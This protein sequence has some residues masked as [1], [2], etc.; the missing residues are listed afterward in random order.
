MRRSTFLRFSWLGLFL[1][2]LFAVGVYSQAPTPTELRASSQ[3]LMKDGNF[4]QAYDGFRKLALDPKTD[5]G[6]VPSDLDNAVQCLHR[7][8]RLKEFDELVESTI[9]AHPG[10]WRLLLAAAQQYMQTQHQGFLIGGNFERGPHRGGGEAKNSVERDRIRALQLMQQAMPLAQKDDNKDQVSRFYLSLAEMLLNNRGYFEAWRLQYLADLTKLPDY[11]DGY[12]SYRD[13]SGAPVDEAGNAVFHE[14]PK[15]WDASTTDGQRWRWALAQAVE[16]SPG[17]LNAVR[18]QMAQFFENQF[19]VQTMQRGGR[20]GFGMPTDDGKKNESGTFA[21]HTLKESETIAKL[22]SGIKRFTL[23]DEYNYLKLYQLIIAE[24]KTGFAENAFPQLAQVFENRRQYPAAAKVWRDAIAKLGAG[25]NNWRQQRLDQIVGNWGQFEGTM[26]QPAGQ[27]ATVDFRFRNGDKVKFDARAINVP[28][29]LDDV[30]A[31]LKSDPGNRVDWN[32]VNLGNIGY[33]IVQENEQK[34]VGEAIAAWELELDPR[35]N[36]FDRRIT[37]T[38]PLQKPGAY[39]LTGTM[40]NGNVSKIIMWVADTAIVQKP[41]SEKTLYFL[42]DAVTGAPLPEINVEFF[43]WQQRHLGNNRFQV[44]TTNFAEKSG[45]DGLLTPDPRDLKNDFQWLITARGGTGRFAFLGFSNVWTSGIYD[46]EYNQVRIFN[47]TDRPVYRPGQQVHFKMWLER[48]QYDREGKSEFAG[49]SVPIAIHNPK[50]DKVYTKTLQADEFGGLSGELTLPA[51]AMLGQYHIQLDDGHNIPFNAMSGNTFRVEEYKKPEFEVSVSA[52]TEPVML[53][54]KITAKVTAKYYFGSPVTKA[55]VKYKILRTSYSDDWY[56]IARWDWC[57]GPGYWWFGY[58]YPWYKGFDEWAGCRRPAPWWVYRGNFNPPELVAEVER[59]IGPEGTVDVEIDTLVAKELHGNSDHQYTITAEVRDES[60]RTIVGEGKVL[61]ARKPFRVFAWLDRGYYRVGEVI[62]ARFQAQTL[63]R[64]PVQ[65]KGVLTLFKISYDDKGQPVETPVQTWPLDTDAQGAAQQQLKASEKGQYRL[66]LSVTD[67]KKH[68]IEGAFIFTI[69]GDGFDGSDFRFSNVELIPDRQEYNPGDKV[70]LQINTDRAGSTVLLFVRPTNGIYLP[71]QVL[72]LKGKSQVEEIAVV[73]RDMPNFFVEAVTISG[74]QVFS[75]TKEIVVPPEKRILN[76]AVLPSQEAYKPGQKGKVKIHLTDLKGEN[77][78]GST[79]LTMYDKS[80]EY[81][82]GGSNVGDIKEFFWKWRRQHNPS[83]QDSLARWSGNMTLP[84]KPGMNFLGVFGVS[85][86]D[87]LAALEDA[88]GEGGGF[89]GGIGG[90]ANRR[91][92]LADA[93]PA[94]PMAAMAL[95]QLSANG[96]AMDRQSLRKNSERELQAAGPAGP[97]GEADPGAALVEPTVRSNFADTAKW[98]ASLTTDKT[99]IAEVEIDMPENL[100]G[101]KIKVWGMGAGT[102][103]GSGEAEVVTRK[104]LIV[105]LQAPRFFVQKDEVVLSANVHNYLAAEKEVTVVLEVPGDLLKPMDGVPAIVKVK[106]P[107]NGEKRIDWRCAVLNEGQVTVRMKALTDEESDAVEMKFP[108]YVHGM[109]K[110]ESW[111]GTVRPDRDSAKVTLTVPA[112]RRVDQSALEIRYSPSLAMAMVDAL[113]Y[114]AEFPYG[115]TEQ[116]LNR[117]LP[118]V[119]TQ[120]TLLRMNLNLADIKDKRTNLNAQE[121]GDDRE[122]AKQ[123][124]RFDRNPVF[125]EA[126]LARMVKDGV[127]ALTEQQISDGGW[128]WFSGRGEQS[129]PH[130]TAVVVHGL[131]LAKAN[132]VALVPGVLEKGEAWLKR[133]QAEQLQWLK[134]FE[135]KKENVNKKQYADALDAMVYMVLVDAGADNVEMRDRLYRDRIELPVYAKAMFGLALD[136]V[137]DAEKLAMM[138]Q[139]I[140]QFLVQDSE[141]ETAYLKLPENNWWWAWWGSETEANAYYLKL[142]AKVEPKGEKAPRLVKYLLNN[143]KHATYWNSTRDTAIAVEAFADYVKA[144]GET[145]PDMF[146]EVWLDGQKLK[147]VQ[148]TKDN[149]FTYDNK[150]LL[151]GAAVKDGKHEIELRRRGKGPVY[152]NAYLTNFT[153]EDHI[154]KAG[155]EVK[156]QRQYYKLVPV[157]ASIKVPGTRSQPL[158]QKVAKFE[159]QLLKEGDTLKSGDLVEI[160]LLIDSKNDYEYLL[161]EDMKAAGFEPVSQQSGHGAGA[162]GLRTYV[163]YRDNRVAFFARVLPRGTHSVAYRMRAEI[164]GKFAALPTRASAMYAP[165]LRGNSDEIKL[166]IV[167]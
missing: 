60:R 110:T 7:L 111:A 106:V 68:T 61:V 22:A 76:V 8:G 62:D 115:C 44:V 160:E 130:T 16:N 159:R 104:D 58:D 121:I 114:L 98:V 156:V 72:R 87:E 9:A 2:G 162:R 88:K 119:I 84:N 73:Q 101:W 37:I 75:E 10:N 135:Q 117:F 36:H 107:A 96:A 74:G 157:A 25:Q 49:K 149:L 18:F 136:K 43:G 151:S 50:N 39:L 134:N 137:G 71:P 64:K 163:E 23:P 13:Y 80:V 47:M 97:G 143:R 40:A 103:V 17:R 59:E 166:K 28:L 70:K 154:T 14:L 138:V 51:D 89:G 42:A 109:L 108:S 158:E 69:V 86:A 128:G 145:E 4:R 118:S 52:P 63:D 30:K 122:R 67:A 45:P 126:E 93:Q 120:K 112:E 161:F 132:D 100:T 3:K 31:Y 140:D 147:E 1:L 66:A 90:G 65:G 129:W 146:V 85:V 5:A 150:F 24:P 164:P 55:T 29:L 77:F 38:T 27:G 133:Y 33:R 142:L 34:F 99:G 153:L 78:V 123:W 165:E 116:T 41:L 92:A 11:D 79:V 35:E 113:P 82:S 105:R 83:H 48:S 54:E 155:L 139:N 125:D 144:T 81:I 32:R 141:N 19:G 102:R 127:K 94:A 15:S 21:L 53:G 20:R 26:T 56:P 131:Q 124:Q 91:G 167:D 148:I 152:F 57:F 95:D 6:Q 46:P 12:L